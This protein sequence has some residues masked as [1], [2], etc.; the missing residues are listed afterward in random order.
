MIFDT[1]AF[2]KSLCDFIGIHAPCSAKVLAIVP[3]SV[4]QILTEPRA[5]FGG[6][7]F[8]CLCV[9]WQGLLMELLASSFM[10]LL[11]EELAGLSMVS[12]ATPTSFL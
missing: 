3:G 10:G 8:T 9:A 1:L 2:L 6:R 11:M 5:N 12:S 7:D 4:K